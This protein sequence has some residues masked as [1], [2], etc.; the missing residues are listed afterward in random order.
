MNNPPTD[1]TA[2]VE[3]LARL[4]CAAD[5]HVH[6]D[7]HPTWQQLVGE[8][9][10]SIRDDYRK[11]A[12]WLASRLTVTPPP[13]GLVAV[14]PT[15]TDRA[16]VSA[17]LWAIAEHH[18][19]AE[20]ICCE[21]LDPKHDLCA[22]GYAALGMAKTLLVDSDPEEAWNPAA[23]VLDA[24][25]A[26]LPAGSEDTATTRAD[27]LRE[28]A[29]HLDAKLAQLFTDWPS[30]PKDSPGVRS[31][32]EATAELRRLAAETQPPEP[33]KLPFVHTDDDGDRLTIGAVMASTYDGEAPV[34]AVAAEQYHGDETATV[35]VRPERV[36]QV[37][38]ALRAARQAAEALPAAASAGV[39]TDEENNR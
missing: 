27:V 5:V 8:P 28:G 24:V 17:K 15:T 7:D 2:Y 36:E 9:G 39:Q 29:D 4:L 30:E 13:A 14:P 22:K 38:T 33:V 37:V 11:A 32:R 1:A 3:V 21:P 6:G 16:A 19:V 10:Q 25:L 34:V 35:Y 31:W 18:I 20:W 26:V 23:P 12:G